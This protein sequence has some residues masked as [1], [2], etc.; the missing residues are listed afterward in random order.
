M[1]IIHRNRILT[2]YHVSATNLLRDA[3]NNCG[4]TTPSQTKSVL[5]IT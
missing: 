2:E 3:E 1:K 4:K 5:L